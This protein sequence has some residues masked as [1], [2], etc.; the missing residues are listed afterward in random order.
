MPSKSNVK[1]TDFDDFAK[2]AGTSKPVNDNLTNFDDF[3]KSSSAVEVTPKTEKNGTLDK[4]KE[5]LTDAGRAYVDSWS[6][7]RGNDILDYLTPG[8]GDIQPIGNGAE[9]KNRDLV[10]ESEERSPIATTL[11]D[12]AGFIRSP[13]TKSFIRLGKHG[14]KLA[15]LM[16]NAD[17]FKK[18]ASLASLAKVLGFTSEHLA[19][20]AAMVAAQKGDASAKE[21]SAGALINAVVNKSPYLA[22]GSLLGYQAA[23]II[24]GEDTSMPVKIAA[25]LAA[26]LAAKGGKLG[27]DIKNSKRDPKL[28]KAPLE[29]L[30]KAYLERGQSTPKE[31]R[32]PEKP[33]AVPDW[34]QQSDEVRALKQRADDLK[35]SLLKDMSEEGKQTYKTMTDSLG[36]A[37]YDTLGEVLADEQKKGKLL[38]A[39]QVMNESKGLNED[40]ETTL[41]KII[42]HRQLVSENPN[43]N[44]SNDNISDIIIGKIRQTPIRHLKAFNNVF[45][46]SR[47]LN[48]MNPEAIPADI[49]ELYGNTLKAERD[50]TKTGRLN[51]WLREADQVG[52]K[53]PDYIRMFDPEQPWRL[54]PEA[55]AR[56]LTEEGRIV[57]TSP[58][59]YKDILNG[60]PKLPRKTTETTTKTETKE[61]SKSSKSSQEQNRQEMLEILTGEPAQ[62]KGRKPS[63]KQKLQDILKNEA[64][65][66]EQLEYQKVMKQLNDMREGRRQMSI[67]QQDPGIIP[68]FIKDAVSHITPLRFSQVGQIYEKLPINK[69]EKYHKSQK[70]YGNKYGL[71]KSIENM[72]PEAR[73]QILR[74]QELAQRDD[75]V[76]TVFK[77]IKSNI[78]NGNIDAAIKGIAFVNQMPELRKFLED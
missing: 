17:K 9:L 70:L 75:S 2:N 12:I 16:G 54:L 47:S 3:A 60:P 7:G 36:D 67:D 28:L 51:K 71:G 18:S 57:L 1:L 22:G 14:A 33:Y 74:V 63:D 59:Q 53:T 24:G 32:G 50:V 56:A 37:K 8:M 42:E 61:T 77:A 13:G 23:D 78:D 4:I 69:I 41:H 49:E 64:S 45:G 27:V 25:A 19:P 6:Y 31:M 11:A 55:E 35:I 15:G 39:L 5:T 76:G 68:Q 66:P 34:A 46:E 38:S 43:Y 65:S 40:A 10:G 58:K 73:P 30:E 48:G 26:G 20:G 29:S 44:P 72:P 52:H 21:L 62:S